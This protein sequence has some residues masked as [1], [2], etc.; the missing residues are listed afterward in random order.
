VIVPQTNSSDET[1]RMSVASF[2]DFDVH[3]LNDTMALR[4]DVHLRGFQ[5]VHR[6]GDLD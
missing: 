1:R 6:C 3:E 4:E 5:I 2:G